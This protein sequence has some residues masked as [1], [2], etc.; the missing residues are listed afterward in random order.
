M[1]NYTKATNF[2]TKDTLPSGDAG[3]IIKGTEID[4]EF[5]AIASAIATKQD[6]T[7]AGKVA[8][9]VT[10]TTDAITSTTGTTFIDSALTA[11]ITPTSLTSK[12]IVM[13]SASQRIY[14]YTTEMN[15]RIVRGASTEV[16]GSYRIFKAWLKTEGATQEIWVPTAM[17]I[18]DSPNTLSTTSYT[19]QFKC[20]ASSG[21]TVSYGSN[22]TNASTIILMEVL[23]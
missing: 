20:Q 19:V 21:G 1:S 15:T 16:T 14:N 9:I 6:S 7:G 3:K 17:S 18:V 5:N 10:F 8:Q 2:A 11:S 23:Q 22:D 12:I 13:V 4:T